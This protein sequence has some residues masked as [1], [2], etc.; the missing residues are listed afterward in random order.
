MGLK[1][2]KNGLI[3]LSDCFNIIS[4]RLKVVWHWHVKK[5]FEHLYPW[6][7]SIVFAHER[8]KN[9]LVCNIENFDDLVKNF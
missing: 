1:L 5:N 7:K 3:A 4:G 9:K 2:P 8:A 6:V